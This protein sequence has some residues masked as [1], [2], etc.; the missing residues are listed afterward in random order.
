MVCLSRRLF[1]AS[2]LWARPLWNR[3]L[4]TKA[5]A[6]AALAVAPLAAWAGGSLCG[7]LADETVAERAGLKRDW[8]ITLPVDGYRA[9]L[10]HVVVGDGLVVAQT[11]DG[12]VH[13][14]RSGSSAPGAPCPG[15]LWS[16][17]AGNP[18]DPLVPAAI[19][20][21]LVAVAHGLELYALERSTGRTMWHQ[22]LRHSPPVGGVVLQDWV[23]QPDGTSTVLRL[24]TNP[25]RDNS[26]KAAPASTTASTTAKAKGA[27]TASEKGK[28]D[29]EAAAAKGK[30][31]GKNG[32]ED[33]TA[34]SLL[35]V[36]LNSGGILDSAALPFGNGLLW[37][38][39][40]GTI[41][42]LEQN[43]YGW[44][45]NE[46][47]LNND[48]PGPVAIRGSSI[49]AATVVRDLARID[50]LVQ[51]G[52]GL[53]LNWQISLDGTPDDGPF[54]AG[55]TLL[56]A[57]GPDGI[58]AF[59]T[60]TGLLLW[61]SCLQG[62]ILAVAAGRVWMLDQLER[63]TSLDLET[64]EPRDQFCLGPFKFP[65]SNRVT[66]RLVLAAPEGT[67]ISLGARHSPEPKSWIATQPLPEPEP[68][69]DKPKTG[70]PAQPPRP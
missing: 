48:Q 49:F 7:T 57:L 23:Y 14:L 18:D 45:R 66:D 19:G 16:V 51:G 24:P 21:D 20:P 40:G 38:T 33:S 42:A 46:F 9:Q 41:V 31:G 11:A 15:P 27:G 28:A 3:P 54:V 53:R 62:R 61:K 8:M 32:A 29:K 12:G 2:R 26:V 47:Y 60:E 5:L 58:R 30:K 59:S 55:D 22:Q 65:V 50:S 36:K 44:Q 56:I 6:T 25:H 69:T 4:W 68:A 10:R 52:G 13:A 17:I 70:R 39:R 1:V 35:P 37:S 43:K 64:G 34:E 63:L 67:I